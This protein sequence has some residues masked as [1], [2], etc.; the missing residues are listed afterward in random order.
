MKAW[1]VIAYDG[2]N[3]V[4][5]LACGFIALALSL[6]RVDPRLHTFSLWLGAVL[7][8]A[9]AIFGA[10][11]HRRLRSCSDAPAG[12]VMVSPWSTLLGLLPGGMIVYYAT[13]PTPTTWVLAAGAIVLGLFMLSVGVRA[14]RIERRSGGR[15][16]RI[17]NR[18]YLAH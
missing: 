1:P 11:T 18:F 10:T 12:A 9:I 4:T 16:V 8:V 17:D 14:A 7:L 15:L 3:G 5:W 13:S 2:V 6:T